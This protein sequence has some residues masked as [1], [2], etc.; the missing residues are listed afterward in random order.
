MGDPVNR[1]AH[2]TSADIECI[3]AIRAAVGDDGF[4]AYCQASVIKYVWRAHRKDN[5]AQDVA[6]AQWYTT[7]LLHTLD[8]RYPDPREVADG[9]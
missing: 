4:Q 2:Y 9:E 1:P 8:A 3:D 5:F 7:M 6:K